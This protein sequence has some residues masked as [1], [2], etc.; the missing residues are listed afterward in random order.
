MSLAPIP[1]KC[2]RGA[3]CLTLCYGCP[4]PL[5]P[6]DWLRREVEKVRD[7]P[8]VESWFRMVKPSEG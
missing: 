3:K 1:P 4:G 5:L 8:P 2:Q 6:S 7:E